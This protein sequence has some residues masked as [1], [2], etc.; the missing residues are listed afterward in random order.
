MIPTDLSIVTDALGDRE[1]IPSSNRSSSI[2]SWKKGDDAP[3]EIPELPSWGEAH[4][5][6]AVIWTAL[7]PKFNNQNDSPSLDQVIQYLQT[8]T[9]TRRDNAENYIRRA[10]RQIDTEYRRQIEAVLGWSYREE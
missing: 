3:G 2:R 9:G 1:D 10:P 5:L 7:G 8:L 6:D 4:G